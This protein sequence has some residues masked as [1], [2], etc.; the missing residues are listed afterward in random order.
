MKS[1]TFGITPDTI[2]GLIALNPEYHRISAYISQAFI[3]F[4][5]RKVEVTGR[6]L[7][8]LLTTQICTGKLEKGRRC[9]PGCSVPLSLVK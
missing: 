1:G 4:Y 9:S 6:I 2:Q 3:Q 5:S 7:R 8:P